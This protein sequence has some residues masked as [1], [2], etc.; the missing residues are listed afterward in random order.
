MM[1]SH[2][3]D[4]VNLSFQRQNFQN[5]TVIHLAEQLTKCGRKHT[6]ISRTENIQM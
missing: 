6:V 3:E 4:K 2:Y 1:A 5:N